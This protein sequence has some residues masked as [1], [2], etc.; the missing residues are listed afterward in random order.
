MYERAFPLVF[1]CFVIEEISE[2]LR[3]VLQVWSVQHSNVMFIYLRL[4][5][6]R[7]RLRCAASRVCRWKFGLQDRRNGI[8]C[9]C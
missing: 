7:N 4:H 5:G 2:D 6:S 3:F 9:S 8:L 1:S